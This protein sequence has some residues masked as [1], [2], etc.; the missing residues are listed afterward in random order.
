MIYEKNFTSG[1]R[2]I[3]KAIINLAFFIMNAKIQRIIVMMFPSR[4]EQAKLK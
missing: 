4:L 3:Q 1:V 2:P